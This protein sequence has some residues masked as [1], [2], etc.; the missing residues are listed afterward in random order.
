M[1]VTG[2]P[3][4]DDLI[5]KYG[6]EELPVK[7]DI[8]PVLVITDRLEFEKWYL[9]NLGPD[10]DAEGQGIERVLREEPL[11]ADASDG[12]GLV[13]LD[14]QSGTTNSTTP[15]IVIDKTF[16]K[17]NSVTEEM[18]IRGRAET[19]LLLGV[20]SDDA[21]G[22][23]TIT[24]ISVQLVLQNHV[25]A[26][27]APLMDPW[28][29]AQIENEYEVTGTTELKATYY[30]ILQEISK[31]I[32]DLGSFISLRIIIKAKTNNASYQTTVKLYHTRGSNDSSLLIPIVRRR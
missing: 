13:E 6:L 20:V 29:T 15:A 11:A 18:S 28:V 27:I 22:V 31:K 10:K 25:L 32:T 4:I 26:I 3:L 21:S 12:I 2:I 23:A 19:A 9:Q 8:Q 14:F 30:S 16:T 17:F 7:S 24:E 1:Q 5:I